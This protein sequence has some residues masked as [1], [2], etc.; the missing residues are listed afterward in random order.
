MNILKANTGWVKKA[1]LFDF[2]FMNYLFWGKE[3][4]DF[5]HNNCS[6]NFNKTLLSLHLMF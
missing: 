1:A 5:L 4:Y 6:I 3:F 2:E